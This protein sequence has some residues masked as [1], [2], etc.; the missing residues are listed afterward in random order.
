MV[1][2]ETARRKL[3]EAL[4]TCAEKYW[5][6]MK[7]WYK[8]K[9][10]KDEFD[11][12][13]FELL[14]PGK[15]NYH[16]QF[17]LSILSKCQRQAAS[18]PTLQSKSSQRNTSKHLH[19]KPRVKKADPGLL[20]TGFRHCDPTEHISPISSK[21]AHQDFV[22]CSQE[23][24]LPDIATLQGRLFLGAWDVGLETI[25]DDSAPLLA[26]AL[27]AQLK[28]ILSL[29]VIR[30]KGS[31]IRSGSHFRYCFGVNS[32]ESEMG[33][34]EKRYES[35][36]KKIRTCDMAEAGAYSKIAASDPAT[37]VVAPISL[38]D[39]RDTIQAYRSSIPSHTVRA[40][41][42]ERIFNELWYPGCDEVVQNRTYIIET[43]KLHEKLKQQHSLRV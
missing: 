34:E 24:V 11:T 12:Q 42:M 29:C 19:H 3:L 2:V 31:A 5:C 38:F 33:N 28:N 20:T 37:S 35:K 32:P 36:A 25:A 41:C 10:T 15:I 27:E 13:A 26:S 22:L 14:G 39:L 21:G 7:L 16:N 4:G 40:G 43:Q 9:I 8:Q 18:A 23:L 1:D 6:N 17:I 30:R